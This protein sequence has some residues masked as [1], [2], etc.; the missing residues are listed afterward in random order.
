MTDV[1]MAALGRSLAEALIHWQ[2][3]RDDPSKKMVN[4]I[5]NALCM[6]LKAEKAGQEPAPL[7][8]GPAALYGRGDPVVKDTGDY[9]YDGRVAF[10]GTKFSSGALRYVVENSDGLLL[11]MNEKQLKPGHF[12]VVDEPKSHAGA[13]KTEK[14]SVT[15]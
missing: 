9:I 7:T 2:R 10:F 4:E 1:R 6:E 5:E 12:E 15:T 8:S 13:E 3:D 11:I 14:T